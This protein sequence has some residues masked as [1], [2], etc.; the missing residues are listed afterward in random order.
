[1]FQ[2]VQL[3]FPTKNVDMTADVC[4]DPLPQDGVPLEVLCRVEAAAGPHR[5][6][7]AGGDVRPRQLLHLGHQS[8]GRLPGGPRQPRPVRGGGVRG[9]GGAV[10]LPAGEV[11]RPQRPPAARGRD[12]QH[13]V[14]AP[15]QSRG[16]TECH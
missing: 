15:G 8:A 7:S 11:P 9:G 4:R 1:M 14:Q 16:R 5:P 10:A 3:Y 13:Q 2:T 12:H 6:S